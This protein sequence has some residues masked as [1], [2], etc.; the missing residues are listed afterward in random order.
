MPD[1]TEERR[2]YHRAYYQ[3]NKEKLHSIYTKKKDT[4]NLRRREKHKATPE[5]QRVK[6]RIYYRENREEILNKDRKSRQKNIEKV[7]K[8]QKIRYENNRER[9]TSANRKYYRKNRITL[10]KKRKVYHQ[11]HREEARQHE[12]RR[13][14]KKHSNGRHDLTVEQWQMI[15][16]HYGHR[17]VYCGQ[18][19][20]RLTM[21]HLTPISQGGEHTMSNVVPACKS[22][23]SRK[24]NRTVLKPVQPM[25]L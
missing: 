11:N 8:Q 19:M 23:N 9:I 20:E 25:L 3:K 22:C 2:A 4:I 12:E 14:A 6:D 21:D 17:C 7:K 16:A 15:K 5:R 18:K 1:S 13:R 24:G 10:L